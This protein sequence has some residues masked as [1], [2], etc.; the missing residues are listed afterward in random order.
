M[1]FDALW[2]SSVELTA[3]SNYWRHQKL[4][5]GR[6]SELCFANPMGNSRYALQS[7]RTIS[8]TSGYNRRQ[9]PFLF[10]LHVSLWQHSKCLELRSSWAANKNNP[11]IHDY[12]K[13]SLLS[14]CYQWIK[15]RPLCQLVQARVAPRPG[16]WCDKYLF[17][18]QLD[19]KIRND[20]EENNI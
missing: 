11:C 9:A 20:D 18:R 1:G 15:E 3:R 17:H 12:S 5:T 2:M 14:P 4:S 10:R 7:K 16:H 13:Q 8:Y 6:K 19:C